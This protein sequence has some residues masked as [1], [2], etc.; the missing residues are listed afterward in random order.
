M[1]VLEWDRLR[2]KVLDAVGAEY[3]ESNT[4][5]DSRGLWKA[6]LVGGFSD[7]P[8]VELRKTM[9]GSVH[10]PD[11]TQVLITLWEDGRFCFSMNG[12]AEFVLEE[13]NQ[14]IE[15]A[16]RYLSA[17]L[18]QQREEEARVPVNLKWRRVYRIETRDNSYESTHKGWTLRVL[19]DS[20]DGWNWYL[21]KKQP[22]GS[23]AEV[24]FG[25]GT[26]PSF[27]RAKEKVRDCLEGILRKQRGEDV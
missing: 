11:G 22:D 5:E 21:G 10:G 24:I 9:E 26:C 3:Q 27:E 12:K 4:T 17:Y 2:K 19:P 20:G 8:R 7:N 1:S 23:V 18:K 16:L 15:E 14:V 25:D 13:L 6:K